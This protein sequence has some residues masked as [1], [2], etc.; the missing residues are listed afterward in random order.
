MAKVDRPKWPL[1]AD[2][3]DLLNQYMLQHIIGVQ[4]QHTAPEWRLEDVVHML[5]V[6][7]FAGLGN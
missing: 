4:F 2:H 7:H 6:S 3:V 5:A 1:R